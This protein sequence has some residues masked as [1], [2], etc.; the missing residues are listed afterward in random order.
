MPRRR[1]FR[2]ISGFPE[3]NYFKP[4]GVRMRDIGEVVLNVE[5]WEAIRL[6]D[7]M[8]K[9]QEEGAKAMGISQ[10]TFHRVLRSARKK[11][12]KAIIEGLALRIE[13][14]SFEVESKE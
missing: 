3:I 10:P 6:V 7:F 12:A 8:K 13:G 5:E 9:S 11:V 4:A 2:R 14:G 1:C